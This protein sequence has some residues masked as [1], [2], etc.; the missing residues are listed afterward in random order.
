MA[1]KVGL[2]LAAV[3][4]GILLLVGITDV[5]STKEEEGSLF[6]F[7][8]TLLQDSVR[9]Q[10]AGS[11]LNILGSVVQG[12]MH[13]DGGKHLGDMLTKG[14][15]AGAVDLIS[16]LASV[17]QAS[18]LESGNSRSSAGNSIDPSIVN[19]M[20]D[21]LST[22]SKGL[23]DAESDSDNVNKKTRH[24]LKEQKKDTK[25]EPSI[26]WETML[27]YAGNVLSSMSNT[28]QKTDG[29]AGG[30]ES[31]LSF[32]PIIMNAI[33]GQ[34]NHHSSHSI[35]HHTHPQFLPPI[36]ENLH[37]YWD[38]FLTTDFGKSLWENSG[39][40]ELVKDFSDHQGNVETDK[41]FDSL[42]NNAFRRRWI[43]S[44]SSFVAQWLKHL[45]NP[46]IQK[47]YFATAQIVCNSFLKS[48]GYPKESLLNINQPAKS[49]S[50]LINTVFKRQ[51]GLQIDSSNY[52][53]PAVGYIQELLKSG[54]KTG[55]GFF[56]SSSDEIESKLSETMES[57]VI[58]PVLRVNRAY[59]FAM[60][61]PEC[62]K[63][64]I[65]IVN[66]KDSLRSGL[67]PSITKLSS[68]AGAWF[69]SGNDSDL[70][71]DLF[72]A[73]VDEKFCQNFDNNC[74]E[75]DLE[76]TKATTEYYHNEL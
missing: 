59:K 38:H 18:Q 41:V 63:Y 65:C 19:S 74:S 64:V 57:Q 16:N 70:F 73:A 2:R 45:T 40:A 51:F 5:G 58:E 4:T 9:N 72:N 15:G 62:M 61:R 8:Q 71:W 30:L 25:E 67:K 44:L 75:F 56:K 14:D 34:H 54:Q 23:N 26:D 76:D 28:N 27:S 13:S 10:N 22:F 3:V 31:F 37:E 50:S 11:G 17:W 1:N 55:F 66:H 47:S 42:E 69:L 20:V 6:E 68:L 7:A 21:L 32:L 24:N 48:Q 36:L 52:V 49:I 29:S 60:K 12:L 53:E 46:E 33:T 39:L 43:K 35:P